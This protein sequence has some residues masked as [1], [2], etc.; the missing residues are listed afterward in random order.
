MQESKEAAEEIIKRANGVC[1]FSWYSWLEFKS[2]LH[3]LLI[4]SVNVLLR[5]GV[6]MLDL[7]MIKTIS[8]SARLSLSRFFPSISLR[9]SLNASVWRWIDLS[10]VKSS[11]ET[12]M[13]NLLVNDMSLR[14]R[15][16]IASFTIHICS[17]SANI[18]K[19]KIWD[20][21]ARK[22]FT[23]WKLGRTE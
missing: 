18:L 12:H 4:I 22:Y 13:L 23:F 2:V 16:S 5:I 19:R 9:S 21:G 11:G 1:T 8:L 3:K 10:E 17:S 20:W 15:M 14:Q 6:A 7:S